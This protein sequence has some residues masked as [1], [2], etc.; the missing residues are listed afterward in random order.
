M[1]HSWNE[2]QAELIRRNV[3]KN[4]AF[5]LSL[6]YERILDTAQQVDQATSLLNE[7]AN[8]VAG[9]VQL[10]QRTQEGLQKLMRHGHVE[11]VHV[12]TE[13]LVDDPEK[14]KN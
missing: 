10:H 5:F 3:D 2:F 1:A 11:G 13:H 12:S 6:C 8:T 7:M 14:K 9:F 4:T